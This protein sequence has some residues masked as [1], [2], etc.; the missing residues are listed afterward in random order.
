MGLIGKRRGKVVKGAGN[1]GSTGS[2]AI[3][4]SL[5]KDD[6]WYIQEG[7][8]FTGQPGQLPQPSDPNGITATGGRVGE[9]STPPGAV[10]RFHVFGQTSTFVVASLAPAGGSPN[11]VDYVVVGG[12]GGAGDGGGGAGGFLSTVEPGGGP[13]GAQ[14]TAF[15]AG[16]NTYPITIGA[17]GF[18]YPTGSL[19]GT[20]GGNTIITGPTG[21]I[22]T[23]NGGGGGG[24]PSGAG[25][26]GGS[27]G[28]GGRDTTPGGNGTAAQGY[29][30]SA[31]RGGAY[32]GGG[33]GG[34]GGAGGATPDNDKAAPGG[35]GKRTD[36][37]GPGY[38]VGGPGAPGPTQQ[39]GW[40]AGGGGGQSY[41][42]SNDGGGGGGGAPR[43]SPPTGKL[44][45]ANQWAGGGVGADGVPNTPSG[46]I[47]PNM[48]LRAG[49]QNTGGGGGGGYMPTDTLGGNG[50]SGVAILRYQ[51]GFI[52]ATAKATGGV[53]SFYNDKIIH[54][55]SQS[56]EL[57]LPAPQG[58]L[59]IE[60]VV[61]G[62]G[63]GGGGRAPAS[64]AGGG[65]GGAGAYRTA[66]VTMEPGT[67]Q[68]IVGAGGPGGGSAAGQGGMTTMNY[69][70]TVSIAAR[71]GGFGNAST[72][73][74]TGGSSS[75]P[76]GGSGGGGYNS[77]TA[78]GASGTYG[79]PGGSVPNVSPFGA[80]GGGGFSA[81]GQDANAGKGGLG[82]ELPATF[83]SPLIGVGGDGP[84]PSTY[85]VAGGG[86]GGNG[87]GAPGTAGGRGGGA[88]GPAGGPWCGAGVGAPG[89]Y[90]PGVYPTSTAKAMT[91][92]G[93]GGSTYN[94]ASIAGD[95]GSGVILIAYDAV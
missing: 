75:D 45:S 7:F 19:N 34:A 4:G 92:S 64:T 24:Y 52:S 44:A 80:A 55:F 73:T 91:G 65:G 47:D 42:G 43:T 20:D 31:G 25:T 86:G 1:P 22:A 48:E 23:A 87:S 81:A 89:D 66:S 21:A 58:P 17:G 67:H 40:L 16:A 54:T 85:F 90:A 10:Y 15:T 38:G 78:G 57:T 56:G 2:D 50:G 8:G 74:D 35:L 83:R 26:P 6:H 51:I 79:N 39:G 37:A 68:M 84:G 27:G 95:G 41:P 94:D 32:T 70:P 29:P 13:T 12:G 59:A 11:A 76:D 36:I 5:S 82:V 60:Y 9:Y 18:A 30:G 49:L 88:P 28:G 46:S 14:G 53:V 77:N 71:G 69:T 33:G 72:Q 62:G 63:G 61:I 93:G 3:G